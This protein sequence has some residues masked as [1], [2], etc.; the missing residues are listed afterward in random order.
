[1]K[2]NF[3]VECL[4]KYPMGIVE[5]R[6]NGRRIG[7]PTACC[8]NCST[9]GTFE[10]EN[11]GK[12]MTF[13]FLFFISLF[14]L[15][16]RLVGKVIRMN[17]LPQKVHLFSTMSNYNSSDSLYYTLVSTVRRSAFFVLFN[18]PRGPINCLIYL[19]KVCSASD[20]KE[21]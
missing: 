16:I 1:M 18:F 17:R 11:N 21:M 9:V 3:T 7:F 4:I 5:I 13:R 12:L 14:N 15:N 6:L 8:A 10:K 2:K 20:E 19:H